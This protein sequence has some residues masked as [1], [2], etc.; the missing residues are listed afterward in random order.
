MYVHM[1]YSLHHPEIAVRFI[2]YTGR[3]RLAFSYLANNNYTCT[4]INCCFTT[5]RYDTVSNACTLVIKLVK[6]TIKEEGG[7][8]KLYTK[9]T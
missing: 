2:F 4:N 7:G 1:L 8:I 6:V 5:G 3:A 9:V